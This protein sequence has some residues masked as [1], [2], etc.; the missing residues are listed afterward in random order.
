MWG[1]GVILGGVPVQFQWPIPFTLWLG[2]TINWRIALAPFSPPGAA[3]WPL[4]LAISTVCFGYCLADNRPDQQLQA[5]NWWKLFMAI[6]LA[7]ERH[8]GT[9]SQPELWRVAH[10]CRAGL[11]KQTW[12]FIVFSSTICCCTWKLSCVD[13][14]STEFS[15]INCIKCI[16][17]SFHGP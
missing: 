11:F 1:M 12:I 3:E 15:D 7:F 4:R 6:S 17:F 14:F 2:L 10:V 16:S 13:R 5:A 9:R 8:C